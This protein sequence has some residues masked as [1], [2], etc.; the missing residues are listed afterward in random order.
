MKYGISDWT[1]CQAW[2]FLHRWKKF[3]YLWQPRPIRKFYSCMSLYRRWSFINFHT[4]SKNTW[5]GQSTNEKKSDFRMTPQRK[6]DF[7]MTPQRKSF[8]MW[9]FHDFSRKNLK[10]VKTA[11]ISQFFCWMRIYRH[12]QE[13]NFRMGRG[14]QVW[15]FLHPA[16]W[17]KP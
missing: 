13:Y 2:E 14:F 9:W 3:S 10:K 6:S 17:K 5:N 15:E 8:Y 12:K 7:R 4:F 16:G 1:D 11:M